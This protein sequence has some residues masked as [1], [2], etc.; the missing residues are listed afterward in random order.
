MSSQYWPEI[1]ICLDEVEKEKELLVKKTINLDLIN[2]VRDRINAIID[3]LRV[4]LEQTLEK[5]H[6]SQVVF[7]I[8]AYLDEQIQSQ[9]LEKGHGNWIPLQK[10]FYGAYNAGSLFYDTI[11]KVLDDPHIPEIVYRIYYFILKLGFVGKYRDAKAHIAKYMEILKDKIS[12]ELVKQTQKNVKNPL[13]QS[14][15][16]IRPR[17]YYM[18]AGVLACFLLITLY[19]S[20]SL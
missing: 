14:K 7:A 11:D 2:G 15:R 19:I 3:Q 10:D 5:Q 4:R 12:V 13:L 18:T 1:S 16:K 20:S 17:H 6:A 9:L 8:V